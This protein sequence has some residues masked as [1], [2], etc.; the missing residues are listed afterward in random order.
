MVPE[1]AHLSALVDEFIL[2]QIE[3]RL[4]WARFAEEFSASWAETKGSAET[5]DQAIAWWSATRERLRT[6]L[7]Q[8]GAQAA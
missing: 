3:A 2:Q 4:H 7:E 6:L 8:E 1:T 5:R